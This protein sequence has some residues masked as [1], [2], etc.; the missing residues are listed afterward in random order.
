[1]LTTKSCKSIELIDPNE[2]LYK[3]VGYPVY[4]IVIEVSS[5][6]RLKK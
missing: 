2:H 6:Q 4:G 1:M 5:T 3:Y